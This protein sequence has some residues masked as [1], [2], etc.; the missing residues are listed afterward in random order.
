MKASPQRVSA[1]FLQRFSGVVDDLVAPIENTLGDVIPTP[2]VLQLPRVQHLNIVGPF[3][4]TDVSTR[5]AVGGSSAA[6]P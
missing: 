1:A 3:D 6:G 4:A 5:R 2:Q